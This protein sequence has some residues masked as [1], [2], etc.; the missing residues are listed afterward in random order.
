MSSTSETTRDIMTDAFVVSSSFSS[1]A[2]AATSNAR[3]IGSRQPP[4]PL[5]SR[6]RRPPPT[7]TARSRASSKPSGQRSFQSRETAPRPG[8]SPI[9]IAALRSGNASYSAAIRTA[10]PSHRTSNASAIRPIRQRHPN[11]R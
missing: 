8:Q 10:Q 4:R 9:T 5:R 7:P 1:A 11:G 3:V 2:T 6:C